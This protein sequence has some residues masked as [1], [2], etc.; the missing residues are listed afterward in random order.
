MYKYECLHLIIIS[1]LFRLLCNKEFNPLQQRYRHTLLMISQTIHVVLNYRT[2][3]W[4]R[5]Q[6][7]VCMVVM[8]L[9]SHT[10]TGQVRNGEFWKMPAGITQHEMQQLDS[11]ILKLYRQAAVNPDSTVRELD[12]VYRE[13]AFMQYDYGMA[14]ALLTA[15]SV[16]LNIKNEVDATPAF[17]YF[18]K[19]APLLYKSTEHDPRIFSRWYTSMGAAFG[20]I[21]AFDSAMIYFSK[22]LDFALKHN[23]VHDRDMALNYVN[24]Q[25]IHYELRQ[26]DKVIA[27]A[28][29]SVKIASELNL[30]QELYRSYTIMAAAYLDL[31]QLD[32][33]THYISLLGK[34]KNYTPTDYDH[35]LANEITAAVFVNKGQTDKAIPYF[36]KAIAINSNPSP[37]SLRGL[38]NAYRSQKQYMQA[39]QYLLAA[40]DAIVQLKV[41]PLF[42]VGVHRDLAALYDSTGNYKL[43]YQHRSQEAVLQKDLDD[44]NKTEVINTLENRFHRASQDKQLSDNKVQLM[45]AKAKLSKQNIWI[46][47][48][49]IVALLL[50]MLIIALYQ[51]QKLQRQ[52]ERTR[53]QNQEIEK[54][55]AAIDAEE[56]ERSRIG[57]QL[58]DDIMV[59]L[60]IVKMNMEALPAQCPGIGNVDDFHSV[61]ELLSIAGRDLR[62]TAHNLAPDTLLADGLTQAL[63]YFFKNVQYRSKLSINFQYY[64]EPPQLPQETEINIYRIAQELIQNI[65]KHA[66]AKNV[67]IQLN[68]RA[69]M[70]TLTIEDDGV[71]FDAA[72][73]PDKIGI[74][75][76]SIRSRLKVMNGEMDIHPRHPQGTSVTIEVYI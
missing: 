76:K 62:Q 60:S 17:A 10:T 67:L 49:A 1:S 6:Y 69:D 57:R 50:A 20:R 40:L 44:E 53:E 39:E 66:Q 21:G 52:K 7:I 12:R 41:S 73:S 22:S 15:G 72:R 65:I 14:H 38:G 68:Y 13:C 19:A 56:K 32:S 63:L 45:A 36:K 43:A 23:F 54:L 2:L 74:G 71:G 34:V 26:F 42:V 55:R 18:R 28:R 31:E 59:Q 58:H 24:L 46:A 29:Q 27:Y 51:K 4:C 25:A 35:K 75:L 33:C 70:L 30:G 64:G 9:G 47:G 16:L 3:T 37:T 8:F 5:L 48:I 61:K 11:T